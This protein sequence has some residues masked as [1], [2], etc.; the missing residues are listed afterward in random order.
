M[1]ATSF[2]LSCTQLVALIKKETAS[3]HHVDAW[4]YSEILHLKIQ[5]EPNDSPTREQA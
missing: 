2:D 4:Y 3:G 1:K 5:S